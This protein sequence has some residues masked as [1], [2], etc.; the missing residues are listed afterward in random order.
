LPGVERQAD[1]ADEPFAAGKTGGRDD[2]PLRPRADVVD[3]NA[4]L[5]NEPVRS[6]AVVDIGVVVIR[7]IGLALDEEELLEAQ[8]LRI[9]GRCG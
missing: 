9:D 4:V 8:R 3:V 6:S 1:L 2:R 5:R 7:R